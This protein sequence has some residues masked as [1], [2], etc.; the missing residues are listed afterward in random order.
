MIRNKRAGL[1]VMVTVGVVFGALAARAETRVRDLRACETLAARA[2]AEAL[3]AAREWAGQGGGDAARLCRASALFHK[4]EFAAAGEAFEALVASAENERQ[5]AELFDR[6]G[7][8]ALRSG[9]A[10]R[11]VF[12]YGRAIEKQPENPELR[13]DRGIAR[14]ELRKSRDAV[15]DFTAALSRLP[16]RADVYFYRAAAYRELVELKSASADLDQSLKLRPGDPETLMLRGTVRAEASDPAGA[17]LDWEEVVR[18]DPQSVIGKAAAV[19]LKRL[20]E[21]AAIVSEKK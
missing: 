6:A 7:W 2:P 3:S 18:R 20:T 5:M 1:L 16:D 14:A 12:L 17:R 10:R 11:A 19:A 8:A 21:A 9:D 4:G 15:A 13:V